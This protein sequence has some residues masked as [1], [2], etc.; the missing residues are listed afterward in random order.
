M[1]DLKQSKSTEREKE[2]ERLYLEME[3]LKQSKSTER[4]SYSLRKEPIIIM[5]IQSIRDIYI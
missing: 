1:E 2:R 3:D 4:E 5:C